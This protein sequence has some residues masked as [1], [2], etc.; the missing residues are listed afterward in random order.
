MQQLGI[1]VP[2]APVEPVTLVWTPGLDISNK[3]QE[4]GTLKSDDS[5]KSSAQDKKSLLSNM[6]VLQ[7]R[8]VQS[9]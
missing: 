3:L 1:V 5:A 2:V 6:V 9:A 4:I 8:V 7:Q